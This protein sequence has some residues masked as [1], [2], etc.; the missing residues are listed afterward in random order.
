MIT[1]GVKK[2]NVR[3]LS[4]KRY[5][6]DFPLNAYEGF[7]NSGGIY[8]M[9]KSYRIMNREHRINLYPEE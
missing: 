2:I 9:R 4:E 1:D 8:V 3:S 7:I 6:E 5:V